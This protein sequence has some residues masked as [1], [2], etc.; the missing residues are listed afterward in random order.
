MTNNK[1]AERKEKRVCVG[2]W[3][4]GSLGDRFVDCKDSKS[5]IEMIKES[6][7]VEEIKGVEFLCPDILNK[8]SVRQ[9]IWGRLLYRFG[10]L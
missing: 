1:E 9:S 2:I 4:F 8:D 6:A 10:I 5:V 3:T 7:E